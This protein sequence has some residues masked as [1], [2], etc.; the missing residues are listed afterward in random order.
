MPLAR[1]FQPT[2]KPPMQNSWQ[3]ASSISAVNG[4]DYSLLKRIEHNPAA[5]E[6]AAPPQ[7]LLSN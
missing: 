1:G 3:A 6:L 7:R 5:I 2:L 4:N